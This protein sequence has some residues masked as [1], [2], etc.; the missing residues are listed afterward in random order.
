[1]EERS[2]LRTEISQK[3]C[4]QYVDKNAEDEDAEQD[5]CDLSSHGIR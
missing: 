1:V 5:H 3:I 2:E 4:V